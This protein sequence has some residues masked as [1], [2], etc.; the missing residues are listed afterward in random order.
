MNDYTDEQ[1]AE[2]AELAL[3]EEYTPP[4]KGEIVYQAFLS[5]SK[6][7]D[8]KRKHPKEVELVGRNGRF[9]LWHNAPFDEWSDEIYGHDYPDA[10][11]R[12][13][14]EILKPAYR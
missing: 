11:S 14:S 3:Q 9:H 8:R 13:R 5:Q 7:R 10:D 4:L 6:G 2:L 12:L 1:L